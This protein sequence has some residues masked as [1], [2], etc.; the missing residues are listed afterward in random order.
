MGKPTWA[1]AELLDI[2]E[3]SPH[4]A[5]APCAVADRCGGCQY[6]HIGYGGQCCIK[7]Q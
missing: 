5:E 6:Q 4:R 2:V 7:E 1:E 3:P